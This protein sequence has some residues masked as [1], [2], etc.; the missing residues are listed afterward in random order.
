MTRVVVL[1]LAVLAVA[2]G[3][4]PAAHARAAIGIG[5]QKA[6]MFDDPRFRELGIRHARLSVA[7][8]AMAYPWQV[9]EID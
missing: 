6:S 3:T 2:A 8:D 5:D 7:W 4:A 1:A 9:Q